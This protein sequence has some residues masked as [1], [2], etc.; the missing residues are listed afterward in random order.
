MKHLILTLSL[1]TLWSCS[2]ESKNTTTVASDN[3]E[4]EL[5]I[6]E[7]IDGPANIRSS[8]NGDLLFELYDNALVEVAAKPENDWYQV[9]VYS[10]IDYTEFGMDS[11]KKNSPIMADSDTIGMVHKSHEV[12]SGRGGD[13]AFAMLFGYT[14]K[15]NIKPETII[16][17]IFQKNLVENGRK[18]SEWEG[19]IESFQ[20][21]DDAI[22]YDGFV[23]Y[24]NYENTIDDPS[25]GF[26]IVLLFE[27][28]NLVGI[29][30]SR[31]IEIDNSNTHKLN[32]SYYV[33]FFNDY[34]EKKQMLFIDYMNE[35]IQGVD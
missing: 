31:E 25:P 12:S 26:R 7:R 10:D 1:F 13:F 27:K 21:D 9:L 28:Q 19:F 20:L 4:T 34:P 5:I 2:S 18:F 30:H 14:H 6:G 29:I 35:W 33:T 17:T 16:E 8:P 23:S 24:Y 22:D 15:N 32:W 3:H 11:I